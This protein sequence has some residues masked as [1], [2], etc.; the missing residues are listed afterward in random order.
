MAIFKQ[1]KYF[2]FKIFK[3]SHNNSKRKIK[4]KK[5]NCHLTFR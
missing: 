3:V 4:T 1:I 2:S 5:R